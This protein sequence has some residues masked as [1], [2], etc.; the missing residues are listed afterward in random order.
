MRDLLDRST[1]TMTS[2]NL[3]LEGGT[4]MKSIK[5]VLNITSVILSVATIILVL[6]TWKKAPESIETEDV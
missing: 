5:F 2:E 4:T 3:I 6:A 1:I